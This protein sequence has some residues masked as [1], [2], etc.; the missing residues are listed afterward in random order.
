MD[1]EQQIEQLI[2]R[3]EILETVI[4]DLLDTL[5][6]NRSTNSSDFSYNVG[7]DAEELKKNFEKLIKEY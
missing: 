3:C 7:A 2:S 5:I 4:L 1:T 6:D